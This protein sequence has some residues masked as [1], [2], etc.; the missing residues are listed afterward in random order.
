M[1]DINKSLGASARQ[2]RGAMRLNGTVIPGW[3]AWEV[4]NNAF[5][6]ADT[7]HATFPLYGLPK[8]FGAGWF[9]SQTAIECEIFARADPADPDNY[10]PTTADL[11]I[12]GQVDDITL[13]PLAGTIE[14]S[15]RDYTAKLID[16]KTSESHLN[17]T[18]SQIAT[19][20]AG[21]E[22]LKPVVTATSTV[23]GTYYSQ[24]HV[25]INQEQSEWDIL[26][27]LA[28]YENF[29]VFVKGKE[30]HFQPKASE[31][32]DRYAITYTFDQYQPTA[33]VT[34]IRFERSLTIIKGVVVNVRSW[35]A[36]QK[37]AFVAAWPKAVKTAKPGQLGAS[38]PLQ[39]HFT[40]PGLT[41]DQAIKAAHDRYNRIVQH[42]VKMSADLPGDDLL[43]CSKV[44][45]VRGTSTSWDQDYYPDSVKRSMSVDEGY[46]MTVTGKNIDASTEA[47]AS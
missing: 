2:P 36:K 37:K 29:D 18:A 19:L 9:A 14:I 5:R 22:G 12:V 45:Q 16:T 35:N 15:G 31:T 44:V 20:I 26:V 27:R 34:A 40:I 47:A 30:L 21:R 6:A 32:G 43:D 3:L 17:Q 4:D 23:V 24:N 28:E 42:T 11:L 10:Q 33:S 8:G 38:S 1:P 25:D 39:Y 13:D 7:F 41:Q 46:R